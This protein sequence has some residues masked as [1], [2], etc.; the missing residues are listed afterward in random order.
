M[1]VYKQLDV[2]G[3]K[4]AV[5][6]KSVCDW[7]TVSNRIHSVD[8]S[9]NTSICFANLTFFFLISFLFLFVHHLF[10][11]VAIITGGKQTLTL[12]EITLSGG[13]ALA[14]SSCLHFGTPWPTFAL[15][16]SHVA[17]PPLPVQSGCMPL[18]TNAD[19]SL[20]GWLHG[21]YTPTHTHLAGQHRSTTSHTFS[22]SPTCPS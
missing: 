11:M 12:W 8:S 21:S 6:F 9:I 7:T 2:D 20:Q 14:Q 13:S 19:A 17:L 18:I 4:E 10:K 5:T 1:D 22:T 15:K 3:T 16:F